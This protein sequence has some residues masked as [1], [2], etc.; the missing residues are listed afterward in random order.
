[1]D[2]ARNIYNSGLDRRPANFTPLSPIGF[3]ARAARAFPDH[4]AV[5]AGERRFTYRQ[6]RERCHRLASAL[7]LRGIGR[8]DTVAVLAPNVPA[9]L[10]AHF[11]VPMAG[12]VI[13]T[14]NTRLD[15]ANIG[16]ILDHGE[17]KAFL[18]DAELAPVAAEALKVARAKPLV[19]RIDDPAVSPSDFGD[20]EYEALLA[21]GDPSFTPVP[22]A[23]EWDAI[24][25]NYTS[26]TTGDPKGVVFSHRATYLNAL[27]NLPSFRIAPNPV[28]LWTLPMFHCN[29]WCFTW[30]I[31]AA[32]GTH[33]CLRRLDPATVFDLIER[34]GVNHACG[35]PVV[36]NLLLHAAEI[37]KTRPSRTVDF[38]VGGAPPPAAL[39]EKMERLNFRITHGYGLTETLGPSSVCDWH[40]EWNEKPVIERAAL[41][42]RQGVPTY[43]IE[44][45]TVVDPVTMAPVPADGQ[46]L[47][48]I[49]VRGSTIMSGYLK[50]APTT[51]AAFAQGWFHTGD[52]A[53]MHPDGYVE[54][55]DRAKDIIISGGENIS[56]LEVE[57]VLYRHPAVLEAAVVA[58]PDARWGEHP[59][60]FIA[61][62]PGESADAATIIAWC[63]T[64]LAHFK[65]PRTVVF[66]PLP[67]TATGKVQKHLLRERAR[68]L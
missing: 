43:G 11:A 53:V 58:R 68:A 5:I 64:N 19:V 7:A 30:S 40:S 41:M 23:D 4:T 14:I 55:R 42:A 65:V 12:A 63:R 37:T 3:L 45:L 26:G 61:L 57:G 56:S 35:A 44:D 9:M 20:I 17:A 67:K 48:E 18:V 59:C 39:L 15:A 49:V 27:S 10:E 50:N 33:V 1:M 25:L 29:G 38:V 60:A 24:A 66:G 54:I 2:R 6:F 8:G 31:T 46:T 28:Y 62:K 16:F 52:L 34:H 36:L 47:G 21:E 51:G 13:N 32:A 22:V